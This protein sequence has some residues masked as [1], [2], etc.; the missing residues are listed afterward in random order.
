MLRNYLSIIW[1]RGIGAL[2]AD[3]ENSYLGTL[4]W[5]LEPLL[6]TGLFYITF[7]TGLRGGGHGVEFFYFLICALLPFKWAASSITGAS[8]S[9]TSNKGI[10]EQFYLPKW[11]F[12]TAVN[13]SMLL[14][15]LLVLPLI[16]GILLFG[17]YSPSITWACV[18]VVMTCQL[19]VNLGISYLTAALVP[20]VPDLKYLVSLGVTVILFTSGIFFDINS[21][22]E[23]TQNLLR[24]NPYVDI[25]DAY[26][27]VLLHDIPV[28]FG[29]LAYP[30]FFGLICFTIGFS[31]LRVFDK[32]YPRVMV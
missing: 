8:T 2:K 10:L 23:T 17:G 21:R 5:I 19:I 4:W 12:P 13:L 30:L 28:T 18:L 31:I 11:I 3:A 22:E 16:T 20:L 26:R 1:V 25:F 29:G 9:I 14:R 27:S 32:Y 6:L 15:F 24:L 7:A